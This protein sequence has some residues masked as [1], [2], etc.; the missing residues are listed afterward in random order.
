MNPALRY[1]TVLLLILIGG[2]TATAQESIRAAQTVSFAVSRNEAPLLQ[3]KLISKETITK[4]SATKVTVFLDHRYDNSLKRSSSFRTRNPH[5][6]MAAVHPTDLQNAFK[7]KSL[8][9]TI[10]N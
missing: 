3:N 7:D 6:D 5:L 2:A 1:S 8:L 10:T 4:S 9:L